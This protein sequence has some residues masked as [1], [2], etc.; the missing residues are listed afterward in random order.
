M[1]LRTNETEGEQ[2]ATSTRVIEDD[3]QSPAPDHE[4]DSRARVAVG[5]GKVGS[6][7]A[8]AG[9]LPKTTAAVTGTAGTNGWYRR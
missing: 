2:L 6:L 5:A 3:H 9:T 1:H 4:A 8:S 7:D